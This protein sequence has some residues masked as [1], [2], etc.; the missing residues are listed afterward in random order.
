MK[1]KQELTTRE[2]AQCLHVG[3][4][5]LYRMMWTGGLPATKRQGR[6]F[7]SKEAVEDR[8]RALEEKDAVA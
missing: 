6:W 4:D 5:W 8:R 3:I 1:S 2:A 7:I